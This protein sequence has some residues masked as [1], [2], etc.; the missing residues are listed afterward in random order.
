MNKLVA[1]VLAGLAAGCFFGCASQHPSGA[2]YVSPDEVVSGVAEAPTMYDIESS[3][4]ALVGKMLASEQFRTKYDAAKTAKSGALPVMVI[5]NIDNKTRERIQYRLDT[6]GETI[7][8]KLFDSGLFEFKD[9]EAADAIKSR[10][11]CGAD[12]GLE[13]SSLVQT[14]GEHES[15]DFIVL[16]DFRHLYDVGGYHIYRL[17]LAI[18]SLKTGKVIWEGI[19]TKVKL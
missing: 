9:D 2:Q 1:F 10:I 4:Q 12:G 16:G 8:T 11:L 6:A 7:R 15:P 14:M 5:G 17:R 18:H 19:D 3:A 13:D